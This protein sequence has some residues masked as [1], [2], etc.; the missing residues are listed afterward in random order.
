MKR[1]H[2]LP[3]TLCIVTL[4]SCAVR[5]NDP[6][7]ERDT[8]KDD[9]E[10]QSREQSERIT[11]STGSL[12]PFQNNGNW[13]MYHE[14]GG[15]LLRIAVTDTISDDNILYYRVSFQEHRVDTTDDW[16][17]KSSNG[18]L[19]GHALTG[20]YHLFLPSKITARQDTFTSRYS[21]VSYRFYDEYTIDGHA[22]ENVVSLKYDSP[23]IHGFDEILLADEIGIIALTDDDSRWSVDYILDSCSIDGEITLWDE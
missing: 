9:P 14:S 21:G 3:A 6:Y 23:I 10:G 20:N 16:F 22:F 7:H 8:D 17:Q 15:N 2:L 5:V 1:L 11:F 18:I 19:F 4:F 13:W 12:F